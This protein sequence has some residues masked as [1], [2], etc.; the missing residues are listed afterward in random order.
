MNVM[1]Y[2]SRTDIISGIIQAAHGGATK[3]RIMYGA[4]LSYAQVQEYLSFLLTKG[5]L[6]HDESTGLYTQTEESLRFMHAYD[7]IRE[8]CM[9]DNGTA[10]RNGS[11]PADAPPQSLAGKKSDWD[12][13]VKVPA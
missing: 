8:L 10:A 13:R 2:R 5:L 7:E 6:V 11:I 12:S 4:F 9:I 3:T 1:K